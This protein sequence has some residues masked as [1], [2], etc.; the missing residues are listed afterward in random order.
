MSLKMN[1]QSYKQA[2][3][4]GG[5]LLYGY[6]STDVTQLKNSV[7]LSEAEEKYFCGIKNNRRRYEWLLVRYLIQTEIY[8]AQIAYSPNGKPYLE[9]SDLNISI[10]HTDNFVAVLLSSKEEIGLDVQLP[11]QQLLKIRHKF[12]SEEEQQWLDYENIFQLCQL[13]SAKEAL[14]KLHEKGSLDFKTNMRLISPIDNQEKKFK[15]QLNL[16][17]ENQVYEICHDLINGTVIVWIE[18]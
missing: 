2:L 3:P 10:S 1:L 18:K 15:L 16:E 12:I 7:S 6:P 8:N 11:K 13:W 14:F 4:T 9:D 5:Q 17:S